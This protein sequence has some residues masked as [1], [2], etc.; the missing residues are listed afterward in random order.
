MNQQWCYD[1]GGR[2][3]IRKLGKFRKSRYDPIYESYLAAL[4]FFLC[5]N[6]SHGTDCFI[7]SQ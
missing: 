4:L 3:G 7:L 1:G 6:D 2:V 5:V